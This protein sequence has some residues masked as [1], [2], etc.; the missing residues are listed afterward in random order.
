MDDTTRR[1]LFEEHIPY[2][3]RE[4]D[5]LRWAWELLNEQPPP[6]TARLLID[7]RPRV[8]CAVRAFTNPLVETGAIAG[9]VLLGFMGVGLV[10]GVL[11]S[12]L[13]ER[14]D[15]VSLESFNL[16]LLDLAVLVRHG[17][18]ASS[19]CAQLIRVANKGIAHL[20]ETDRAG[21]GTFAEIHRA[22]LL[23]PTLVCE[24]LYDRLNLPR[25]DFAWG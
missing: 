14:N 19:D 17:P 9:R 20:T 24:S 8:C 2:R 10:K 7:G 6:Q 25:P 3:M 4:V 16:P 5:A 11:A 23:I 21:G 13:P 22:A 1:A 12:F 18:H 15:D